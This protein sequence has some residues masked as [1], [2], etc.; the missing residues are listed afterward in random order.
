[1]TNFEIKIVN[2]QTGSSYFQ[3][4]SANDLKHAFN[5]CKYYLK[6]NETIVC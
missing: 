2:K 4:V 5:K 6:E 1:M 3:K